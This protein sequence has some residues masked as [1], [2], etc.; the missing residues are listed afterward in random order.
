MFL[1]SFLAWTLCLY[2]WAIRLQKQKQELNTIEKD[3]KVQ[4]EQQG[5]TVQENPVEE[6]QSQK[7]TE[8]KTEQPQE[9]QEESS[10][11]EENKP[12][13]EINPEQESS[14]QEIEKKDDN[15]PS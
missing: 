6:E 12:L 10:Q 13:E 8:E 3:K 14:N 15:L 1:R 7:Q 2:L 11:S 5:K 4:Q 9:T